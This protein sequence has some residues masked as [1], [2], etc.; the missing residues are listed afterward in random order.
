MIT[1]YGIDKL[2]NNMKHPVT[3]ITHQTHYQFIIEIDGNNYEVSLA[4]FSPLVQ[5]GKPHPNRGQYL[6]SCGNELFW[7]TKNQL[8]NMNNVLSAIQ[9]ILYKLKLC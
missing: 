2:G 4:R 3:T 1:I 7:L 6:L 9:T 8:T 5:N